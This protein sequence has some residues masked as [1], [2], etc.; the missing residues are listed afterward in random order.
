MILFLDNAESILDPQRANAQEIY[1]VV[2]ELSQLSNICLC[3]TSRISTIPPSCENL[4]I[5]TLSTEAAHDTFYRIY[6]N[7]EQSSLIDGIL[8]RLDFHPLSVTLL[9]TVAHHNKW[10]T[11]R[12]SRE[13]ERRRTDVLCTRHDTSLA[14]T[15]ELSLASPM[16]QELGPD[17]RELLGVVAFFPQGI[18]E[19]NLDWLFSIL[20]NRT[21]VFDTFC[22][23]SLTYRANGFITMLAPLRD[24]LRPKDPTSSP[25]L[26]ATKDHYFHRLSAHVNPGEPGFEE[27][28]WIT[29]EDVNIEHLLDVFTFMDTIPVGVLDACSDFMRHLY[30]HKPRPVMLGPKIEGLP[31]AHPSK[32]Q[33]LFWLSQLFRSTGNRMERKRLLVYSLDIWRKRRNDFQ[34]AEALRS[35][36]GANRSLR[37]HKQ[38]IEQAREALE[39]YERLNNTTGQAQSWLELSWSLYDD[40]QLDVAE[41]AASKA[42]D[43]SGEDNQY[44]V[45]RC[46]RILGII[47][48]SRGETEKA[49]HHFEAALKVASA[50]DWDHILFWNH[51]CLAG[52]FYDENK[53]DEAHVHVEQAKSH[54][55]GVLYR[56]G[57]AMES[58]ARIWYKQGV[59]REAKS[60]AL[61]AT[62]VYE[63]VGTGE[64][65]ER[66]RTLLRDIEEVV[67]HES[68]SNG[69]FLETAPLRTPV[70]FSFSVQGARHDPTSSPEPI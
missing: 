67:S 5:P 52:L 65:V 47:C 51:Y 3:I 26:C 29:S 11:N 12:L 4:D 1:V 36:S 38:G 27:A 49:I 66:C 8:E 60:E 68:D 31:D 23:L 9:A 13:W 30:W 41:E 69:E 58:Q 48:R 54:A 6:K 28:R 33:S 53:F 50:F 10:D 14:T 15:I 35:L 7:G 25:L 59:F 32:P 61:H 56:L 44:L 40:K 20:P 21:N 39:I 46:Y 22:V 17:T 55:S 57:R 24:Y 34:A 42:I 16:F 18:D 70:N 45:C 62:D 63:K 43:L 2:E 19:N 37:L 64:E